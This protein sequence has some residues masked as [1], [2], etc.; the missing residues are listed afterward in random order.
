MPA[1]FIGH[2]TPM[3]ALAANRYTDSWRA[4]GRSIPKPKAIL[5]ISA[6]W[7]T[8]GVGVT[9][10]DMPKT[11]HDFGGFPQALFDMQYPAPGDPALAA[12]AQELLHPLDVQ[13]DHNWGLDHGAW[14]I[15][16]HIFPSADV[17][18]VQLSID[19][20]QPAQYHYDVGRKLAA[21][22]DEGIL[23]LGSGNVVHNLS[24]LHRSQDA[25]PA[26]W[27]VEFND[28]AKSCLEQFN[29]QALIDYSTLRDAARLAVPTP[30]HYLP[31]LYVLGTQRETEK[32][33]VLVDGIDLGSIGMLSFAV[34]V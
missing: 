25:A 3:N 1:A 21:L 26:A 9:A 22:R 34:G 30:D 13:L 18:V 16:V 29:H 7:Y 14:S 33:S 32:L 8:R 20:T 4:F 17:P 6:H 27:A 11:I 19:A 15:L 31:L 23:L 12:R 5:C 28:R 24:L 2:G 10:M